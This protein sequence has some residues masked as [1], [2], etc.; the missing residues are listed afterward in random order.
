MQIEIILNKAA[1]KPGY[2]LKVGKDIFDTS[3]IFSKFKNR[4]ENIK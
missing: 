3:K 1:A 4:I 2:G